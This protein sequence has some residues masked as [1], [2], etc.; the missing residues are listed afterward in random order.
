MTNDNVLEILY[1]LH[2][3][4]QYYAIQKD[5][6]NKP[7]SKLNNCDNV[8]C[9]ITN[10]SAWKREKKNLKNIWET[11]CKWRTKKGSS[12]TKKFVEKFNL[13]NKLNKSSVN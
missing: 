9:C 3:K 4:K 6:K 10:P 1:I 11:N 12:D 13:R 7:K 2:K 8:D 5:A